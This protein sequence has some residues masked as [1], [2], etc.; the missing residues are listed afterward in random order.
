[1]RVLGV[2]RAERFSPNSVDRDK[3][4]L[5]AVMDALPTC[6]KSLVS[7]Y[8]LTGSEDADVVFTMARSDDALH[9][10][11]DME[12]QGVRVLNSA[13]GVRSCARSILDRLMRK[14][15]IPMPPPDT[16]H[17]WWLKRGDAAAQSH[18]DVVYCA[19][20]AQMELAKRRFNERGIADIV[21]SAHVCGDLVKFYGVRGTGF[22]R[23]FYPCDT[24]RT[25]FG[26]ERMNG[27]PQHYPYDKAALM[28]HAERLS[29]LTHT[30]IYGGDC[31]VEPSGEYRI[32]DF[33]DWP[34]LSPCRE[35]AARAIVKLL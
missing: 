21:V 35:E 22:F 33:N 19:D 8:S 24:G 9:R 26:D 23:T 29:E 6:E 30:P 4:I 3:A 13:R 1:M 15:G 14:E 27:T 31:I 10:L 2:Y 20:R 12:R 18:D 16:G 25:K 34:S 28:Q 7:E 32:I 17:G 11:E 5:D